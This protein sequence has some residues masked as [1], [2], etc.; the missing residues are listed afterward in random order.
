MTT[1]HQVSG[2]RQDADLPL[3]INHKNDD[4]EAKCSKGDRYE[5]QYDKSEKDAL[6][7]GLKSFVQ[8]IHWTHFSF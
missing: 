1:T 5:N 6:I 3:A 2:D 8:N 7:Q 4:R